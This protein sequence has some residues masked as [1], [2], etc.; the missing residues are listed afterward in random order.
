MKNRSRFFVL[1]TL[2]LLGGC[3]TAALDIK[4]FDV[5]SVPR[6]VLEVLVD[7]IKDFAMEDAK[8]T[9]K[10]IDLKE[11]SKDLMPAQAQEAKICPESVLS[12]DKLVSGQVKAGD[13]VEGA[14]G[15]IFYGTVQKY[16]AGAS[17]K[18]FEDQVKEQALKVVAECGKLVPAEKFG[19][20]G[21]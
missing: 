6:R 21:G 14:K 19:S 8:T 17:G 10:W 5:G 18:K 16:G 3:S 11:K 4:K 12:L 9:I 7:P 20:F 15:L 13:E 2:L 1:A